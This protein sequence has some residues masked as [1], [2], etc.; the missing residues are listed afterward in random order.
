MRF[1]LVTQPH[2]R[3]VWIFSAGVRTRFS[4]IIGAGAAMGANLTSGLCSAPAFRVTH[5]KQKGHCLFAPSQELHGPDVEVGRT[6]SKGVG[7]SLCLEF[8]RGLRPSDVAPQT[9]HT[10]TCTVGVVAPPP[11]ATAKTTKAV[12]NFMY[13]EVWEFGGIGA[14]TLTGPPEPS[15]GK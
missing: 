9:P 6:P 5:G 13:T 1:R 11:R 3:Y 4:C 7:S 15:F 8:Q 10:H 14:L 2:I 12:P